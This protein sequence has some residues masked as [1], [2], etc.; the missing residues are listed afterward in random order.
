MK[1]RRMDFNV[2]TGNSGTLFER[3]SKLRWLGKNGTTTEPRILQQAWF[4]PE[5]GEVE[6]QDI[7]LELE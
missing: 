4:C 1:E 6:W 3:T 7:P 5:T 2:H